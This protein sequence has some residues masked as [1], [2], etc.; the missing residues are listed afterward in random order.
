MD[1]SSFLWRLP[2]RAK[3]NIL[4]EIVVQDVKGQRNFNGFVIF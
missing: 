4:E 2:V 3:K 1:N